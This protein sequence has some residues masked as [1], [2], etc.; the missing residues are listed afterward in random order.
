MMRD[1]V[2]GK[3]NP[4]WLVF[5]ILNLFVLPGQGWADDHFMNELGIISFDQKSPAPNFT[6]RN[7]N[8]ETVSLRDHRG[9]IVFLNFWASW[10]LPCRVEMPSMEKLYTEFKERD[11][12]ILAIDLK[13]SPNHVKSFRDKENLTFPILLD[14]DGAVGLEYGV[15]SIPTTYLIDRDG[16]L[17][18]GAL[19]PRNW[20]SR[21]A[22]DLFNHL[23]DTSSA[24]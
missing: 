1:H 2:T 22:F 24:S 16:Y 3:L 14:L 4:F 5:L 10:C 17:I 6:L 12:A 9:K 23:L 20:A 8:G 18:G 7:L 13:E 11:L 19:G 15:R 21:E